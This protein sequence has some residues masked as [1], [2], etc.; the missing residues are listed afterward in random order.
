MGASV[1]GSGV[2]DTPPNSVSELAGS[3]RSTSKNENPT[4]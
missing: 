3:A 1:Q 4:A 2:N